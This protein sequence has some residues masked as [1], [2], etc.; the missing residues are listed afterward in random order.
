M[1]DDAFF[2]MNL[3]AEPDTDE[4]FAQVTLLPEEVWFAVFSFFLSVLYLISETEFFFK[5]PLYL[6]SR[7]TTLERRN[8][9]LLFNLVHMFA[10]FVRRLQPL[11][12]AHMVVFL[13]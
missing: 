4:V 13:C 3:Q 1:F 2:P 11:I 9:C 12:Q 10:L 6:N 5:I 7:M 8:P